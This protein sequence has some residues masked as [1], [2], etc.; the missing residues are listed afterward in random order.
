MINGT[1]LILK[2]V[3]F[4]F[5]DGDVPRFPSSGVCISQLIRFARACSSVDDFNNV[6]KLMTSK[7]LQQGYRYHKL[8]KAFFL[9]FITDT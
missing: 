7:L 1:I 6:N 8:R 9:L 4:L 5:F 2:I 3:Y